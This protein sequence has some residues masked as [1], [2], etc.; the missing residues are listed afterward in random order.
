MERHPQQGS[1]ID[2]VR[3]AISGIKMA[4]KR[5]KNMRIHTL[6]SILVIAAGWLSGIT[7]MEWILVILCMGCVIAVELLNTAIERMADMIT[8]EKNEGIKMIKDIS[9][10]AVLIVSVM[11]CVVGIIIFGPYLLD[12]I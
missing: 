5:E 8:L 9:A 4:V 6:I 7:R 2:A 10:G 3:Y 1:F 12:F 11:S